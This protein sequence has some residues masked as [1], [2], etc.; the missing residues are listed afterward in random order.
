MNSELIT[1]STAEC[2][3]H[4]K[5]AQEIHSFSQ[6][7]PSKYPWKID[8]A[9]H[10]LSIIG[11]VFAPT[12]SGVE[13][14]LKIKPHPPFT[15]INDIKVYDQEGDIKMALMMAEAVREITGSSIAIGTTAGIGKGGIAICNDKINFSCSSNIAADLRTSPASVIMQ[16]QKSGVKKA[17]YL[18]E[19]LITGKEPFP[20]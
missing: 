5:I 9:L 12:V 18:L 14:L 2:F 7:Y 3:T 11:S 15:T 4:G 10:K 19:N 6:G 8:P 20:K 17:L 13:T 16:R 1:I